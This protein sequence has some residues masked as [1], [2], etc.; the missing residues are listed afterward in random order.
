MELNNSSPTRTDSVEPSFDN[1]LDE[2]NKLYNEYSIFVHNC[3]SEDD[4]VL[5][6][7]S[8]LKNLYYLNLLQHAHETV[9]CNVDY[10]LETDITLLNDIK[11]STVWET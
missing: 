9:K 4:I 1:K 11:F 3:V 5:N 8:R 2:F 7:D 10:C 6:T